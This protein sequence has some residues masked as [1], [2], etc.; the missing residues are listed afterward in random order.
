MYEQVLN[1]HR[2]V[3]FKRF[4]HVC[5]RAHDVCFKPVFMEDETH[6]QQ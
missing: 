3:C 4:I 5:A 1:V 6:F 2:D